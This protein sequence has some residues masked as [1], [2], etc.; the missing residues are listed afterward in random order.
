MR[1]YAT[2][3]ES[4]NLHLAILPPCHIW[5]FFIAQKLA[6]ALICEATKTH[7]LT[8]VWHGRQI[9]AIMHRYARHIF[10]FTFPKCFLSLAVK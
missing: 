4:V 5:V 2:F 3:T 9:G 1:V 8:G 7:F 6:C 10:Y